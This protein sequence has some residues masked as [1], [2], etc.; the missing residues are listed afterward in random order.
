MKQ[1]KKMTSLYKDT[2]FYS[3]ANWSR[4]LVGF[5]VAPVTVAYFTPADYGYMSLVTTIASFCSILGLLAVADQGLPRF[6]IDSK[7]EFEKT[8]Y[9]A[10]SFF[11]S[12]LAVLFVTSIILLSTPFVP[13]FFKDV[14]APMIFTSLIALTCLAHSFLHVGNNMLKWTFQSPLFMR[15]TVTYAIIG[16]TFSLGGI[17]L[18]DWRAKE[19]LLVGAL[20]TLA[21]GVWGNLS[22]K[23]YISFSTISKRRSKELI[24]Y[25]WPLL[26]LNIFAFF[27]R[28]LDRIF[29]GGLRSL[30]EVGIYS[31]SFAVGSLFNNVVSGFFLAWGPYLLSTFRESWAPK[32]YAEFFSVTSWFG[33]MSIIVLGLWGS[34]IVMLLRPDGVYHQIGVFIPWSVSGALLYYV[35]GYFAPGPNITKKTYWRFIGFLL[36]AA[37]NA[38]LNYTLIPILGILGASIATTISGLIAGIFNQVVSNR[39]FFVPNRWKFCFALIVLFTTIISCIQNDAFPYNINGVSFISRLLF[40]AVFICAGTLPFYADIKAFGIITQLAKMRRRQI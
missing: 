7:D 4:R 30:G 24:V 12:G 26:G 21:A 32:R 16:A 8:S 28:S 1:Q 37:A 14:K 10:T 38:V 31:V 2:V 20:V 25:S 22:V 27:S 19:V 5:A 29:L 3:L 23:K 6:F 34:P 39:L 18:L 15:I 11:V 33:L 35:G 17:L 9:V 13:F 36:A 40:T